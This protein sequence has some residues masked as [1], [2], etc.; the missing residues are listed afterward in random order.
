[1]DTRPSPQLK[2]GFTSG[3]SPLILSVA[4]QGLNT[5]LPLVQENQTRLTRGVEVENRSSFVFLGS[6][7]TDHTEM[8]LTGFRGPCS[9]E[10]IA[11][12]TTSS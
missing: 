5:P 2:V 7:C 3:S 11:P 1:M 8:V 9:A 4:Y 12:Q 6:Y 10:E